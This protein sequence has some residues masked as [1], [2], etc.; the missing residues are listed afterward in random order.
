MLV[1]GGQDFEQVAGQVQLASALGGGA[2]CLT[3]SY[4][5]QSAALPEN[6]QAVV[7]TQGE[8]RLFYGFLF[9][10]RTDGQQ[11]FCTAYD[12]LRYWKAKGSL[13]RPAESLGAFLQRI[14]SCVGDRTRLGSWE[15]DARPLAPFWFDGVSYLDMAY[16][17]L[18]ER[19]QM[20]G[21]RYAF[22][23]EFGALRLCPAGQ[24]VLPLTV[25]EG[26]LAVG[27]QY[28]V[29]I[30]EDTYNMV[31]LA[32]GEAGGGLAALCQDEETVR[33]WGRLA[34]YRQENSQMNAVQLQNQAQVL[35]RQKNRPTRQL[36][37]TCRGDWRVRGG[38][39]LR[40]L[41]PALGIDQWMWVQQCRHQ[42]DGTGHF[43][44]LQLK[45]EE[46]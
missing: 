18:E 35:L 1:V 11:V 3:F 26:S 31:Q 42:L 28:R 4:P 27:L 44:P 36:D 38:S 5:L 16:R 45:E 33:R 41:L 39:G 43:M 9:A 34:L 30:D 24:M 20:D 14:A 6:G 40:V 23:D 15:G 10:S 46:G 17:S 25:G 8:Y 2:D 19:R 37:L 13:Q 29:S 7:F 12:Q 22:F 21:S 32:G